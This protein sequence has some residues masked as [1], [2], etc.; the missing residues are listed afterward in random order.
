M[1]AGR[2][3]SELTR[4]VACQG[5]VQLASAVAAMWTTSG[6]SSE[7]RQ[8]VNHLI[9]HDLSAPEGQ[10]D[11]FAECIRMLAMKLEVW[12]SIHFV[13]T[14][15]VIRIQ[16]QL[17]EKRG[18]VQ[19]LLA[20]Q[21]GIEGC[22]ELFV[23]QNNKTIPTWL[24]QATGDA[25]HI[26][27]GDGIALNFTNSY[28]RPKDYALA[29]ASSQ[30]ATRLRRTLKSHLARFMRRSVPVPATGDRFDGHCLLLKNLFDQQLDHVTMIDPSLFLEIFDCF[31]DDFSVKA[32]ATH[33]ALAGL[34]NSP[35]KNVVL[36][37]SNFSE[38]GRM[39]LAGEMHGYCELLQQMPQ[40]DD[41]VLIIK[42][43]PRDSYEKIERLRQVVAGRYGATLALSDPWTFYLPFES[44]Y[45]RY[46]AP[47]VAMD[48]QTYVATVS[49]ACISLEYLYRQPCELGFGL[50]LVEQEFVPLWR[51]LRKVHERDLKKIVNKL[52]ES[53]AQAPCRGR[54]SA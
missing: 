39:S 54:R 6:R 42:P 28:F 45:A 29:Q 17:R 43:H 37:T 11:E 51:P 21:F 16:A 7:N 52:R 26:C 40:G 33:A 12:R 2:V 41:V 47:S 46:L 22:D 38:T 25:R 9:I 10:I 5:A 53:P 24:R 48:R 32:P 31:A 36:L 23:G 19:S 44:L 30:W 8:L 20:E 15:D 50:E 14:S 1:K 4:V 13:K 34:A 3:G 49:S 18:G 35:G 27:F